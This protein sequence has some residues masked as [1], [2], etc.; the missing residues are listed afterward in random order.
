MADKPYPNPKKLSEQ[1]QNL[2]WRLAT[3]MRAMY[4]TISTKLSKADADGYYLGKTAKAASATTADSA[5]K[6]TQDAKGNVIDQTYAKN[7]SLPSVM[8]GATASVAGVGGTVPAPAAGANG[9]FLRGD[10]T[11]SVPPTNIAD[12]AITT[13]KLANTSVST[14]KL[15]DGAVSAGK[16]ASV[17]DLGKVK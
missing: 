6:A 16:L 4:N 8:K 9:R 2:C 12:G 3:E 13:V 5:T 15:A 10:G 11:W 14:E 17:I 7:A 1:L